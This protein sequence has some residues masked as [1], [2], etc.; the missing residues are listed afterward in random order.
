[1]G[2]GG[3]IWIGRLDL[4]QARRYTL[5]YHPVPAAHAPQDTAGLLP[6]PPRPEAGN[7]APRRQAAKARRDG[8]SRNHETLKARTGTILNPCMR[9]HLCWSRV[10]LLPFRGSVPSRFR[11]GWTGRW[12]GTEDHEITTPR[13]HEPERFSTHLQSAPLLLPFRGSV[14]SRFRDGWTGRWRGTEDHEITTPRQH[15]P[16]RF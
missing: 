11:D 2:T 16:E 13:Q 5:P 15:E 1:M 8:G 12:R 3:L 10:S 4:P 7:L 6:D 14:P 9:T